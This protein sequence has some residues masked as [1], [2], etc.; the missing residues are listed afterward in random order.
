MKKTGYELLIV[1]GAPRDRDA[2]R[3]IFEEAGYV[4]TTVGTTAEARSLVER[5]FFPVAIVELDVERAGAGLELARFMRTSSRPTSVVLL[6]KRRS[7]EAAVEALRIGCADVVLKQAEQIP[8][9]RQVV[10]TGCDRATGGGDG[11]DVL[12]GEARTVLDDAFKI[13]LDMGR[14]VYGDVSVT[15]IAE[16]RPRILLVDSNADFLRDVSSMLESRGW[17]VAAEM[18]GGGALDRVGSKEFHLVACHRDLMDFRGS[19]VVK[20]IQAQ[21]AETL[22]A[23]YHG[24]SPDGAIDVYRLGQVTETHRPMRKPNDLVE[25]IALLVETLSTTVRDRRVIQ[26]FR[27]DHEAFFRRYGELRLRLNKLYE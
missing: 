8:Y 26:A 10:Q 6:A 2:M 18:S 24:P 5:K 14:S 17:E 15:A 21:R 9:L 19:M 16:F 12:L 4:C 20:S 3:R 1:D 25:R 27:T 22:G 23:V 7:F 11:N 13:M